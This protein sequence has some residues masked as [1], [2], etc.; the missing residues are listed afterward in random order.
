MLLT[1]GN[2]RIWKEVRG[3]EDMFA[4]IDSPS[5]SPSSYTYPPRV[6]FK[7]NPFHEDKANEI[8]V[9]DDDE[10][11]RVSDFLEDENEEENWSDVSV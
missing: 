11:K 9:I 3:A 4:N 6:I 2:F 1:W 8:A 10:D 7:R 5:R